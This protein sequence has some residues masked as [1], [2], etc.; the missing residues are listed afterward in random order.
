MTKPRWQS[1]QKNDENTQN[2]YYMWVEEK[3][4]YKNIGTLAWNERPI[5]IIEALA[6]LR[7]HP[8]DIFRRLGTF[9]FSLANMLSEN[10][11]ASIAAAGRT[12]PGPL[13]YTELDENVKILT[14]GT[15]FGTDHPSFTNAFILK[16]K[17]Q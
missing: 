1:M 8:K 10:T 2:P 13:G 17:A 4:A 3:I 9:S 16:G 5:N 15:L 6:L 12:V 11:A 7:E 14:S